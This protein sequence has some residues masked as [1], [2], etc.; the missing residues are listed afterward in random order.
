MKNIFRFILVT[1]AIL[2]II[3]WVYPYLNIVE[4]S[5]KESTLLTYAGFESLIPHSN[6]LYWSI[7]CVWLIICVALYFFIPIAR[8]VF[9]AMVVLEVVTSL[10]FGYLVLTPVEATLLHLLTL[11]DGAL[12]IIA[13]FT[14]VSSEFNNISNKVN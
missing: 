10:F 1:S 3:F 9:L 5:E 4:Y 13:Y 7:L 8:T 12:L 11:S 14:S 2:M 6:I